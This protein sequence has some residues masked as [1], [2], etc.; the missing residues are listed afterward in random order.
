[1]LLCHATKGVKLLNIKN[2]NLVIIVLLAM[3][4]GAAFMYAGMELLGEDEASGNQETPSE[5]SN[6]STDEDKLEVLDQ[7]QKSQQFSKIFKAY[8]IIKENYIEEVDSAELLEG[9]IQGMLSVLNDPHSVYMDVETVEQFSNSIESTFEGI[10]AEVSM[11]NG[12][13]TIVAPIKG[14]PAEK[15]GLKAKDQ[16]LQVDGESIEGLDLYEAVSK[17]RGEK[18]TK[19][20]LQIKRPGSDTL[21]EVEVVRDE[22]PVETIYTDVKTVDGKK[23]GIIQITSFATDTAKDFNKALKD[24]ENQGIDGLIIDVRGNPGGLFTSVGTILENFYTKDEPYVIFELRGG[25]KERYFTSRTEKK[26]YPISVLIDSGSASASEILAAAMKEAGYDIVGETSYGKGSVQQTLPLGDGSDIKLTIYKWLTPTG[27]WIN[28][29]GVK[30]TIEVKQPEFFYTTA[31]DVETP[32][33][34]DMAD[35][36]IANIQKMLEGIGYNPGR[37]DGYFDKGT[38]QAVKQFQQ[39]NGLK[40]TGKVDQETGAKLQEKV[41]EAVRDD[42]NDLQMQKALESLY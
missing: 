18:G 28:G 25:E 7:A 33:A 22:I 40:V 41:V 1:M 12:I 21:M 20:T 2:R 6:V 9:A 42:A 32:F 16:I 4:L 27:E 10:G 14:S 36:E 34:F 31:F 11:E 39:D 29:K 26:D 38:E 35:D 17:I 37:K 23:T 3:I 8:S 13:L 24:L 19:V 15:V 30:P 5:E